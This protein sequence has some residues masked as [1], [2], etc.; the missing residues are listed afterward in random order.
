MEESMWHTTSFETIQYTKGLLL[1]WP[2]G[3]LFLASQMGLLDFGFS[4]LFLKFCFEE[5]TVCTLIS[6]VE[7]IPPNIRMIVYTK[8]I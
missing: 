1:L 7:N 2:F 6:Y 3:G 4:L 5:K 8:K